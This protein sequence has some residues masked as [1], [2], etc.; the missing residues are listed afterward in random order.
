MA[1]PAGEGAMRKLGVWGMAV[2]LCL[3]L[4]ASRGR[5]GDDKGESS[6]G[7]GLPRIFGPAP[8][9]EAK[10]S[11]AAEEARR[12]AAEARARAERRQKRAAQAREDFLRRDAVCTCL[13]EFA[14]RNEDRELQKKV[15]ELTERAWQVYLKRTSHLP[16][17]RLAQEAEGEDTPAGREKP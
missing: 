17:A 5:A 4:A 1:A 15:E 12:A 2:T 9:P 16:T 6:S 11:D 14:I 13:M 10:K 3:G 7:W 8:E